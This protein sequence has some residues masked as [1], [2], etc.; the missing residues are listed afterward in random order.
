MESLHNFN[1]IKVQLKPSLLFSYG[2]I[3]K[4][5]F[6]KGTIKTRV[7]KAGKGLITNFNSI[8]VQLKPVR[9]LRGTSGTAFQFH[10]GTIKTTSI[11]GNVQYLRISIP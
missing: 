10:K 2:L 3:F 8:K 5:Q 6:H 4:F 9:P 11:Q 1:S 7:R